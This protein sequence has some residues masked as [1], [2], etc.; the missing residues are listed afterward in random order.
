MSITVEPLIHV[1]PLW[2]RSEISQEVLLR[3]LEFRLRIGRKAELVTTDGSQ[4]LNWIVGEDD[5]RFCVNM[6]SKYSPWTVN[7]I[8]DGYITIEGG[9]RIGIAGNWVID[10]SGRRSIR[11]ITSLCIRVSKD[12]QNTSG[13]L[14]QLQGSI[15]IVGPPGSGKTTLLR[16]LIRR[17]SNCNRKAIC[18]IDERKEL[19]PMNGNQMC[20][21]VGDRTD[22]LSGCPKSK[23]IQMAIRCMGARIIAI[24]EI[25]AAED[26]AALIEA[27]WC[28]VDILATAHA[29]G[30]EDMYKRPVYKPLLE[31]KLFQGFVVMNDDK[32]WHLERI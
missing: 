20:Y 30:I 1:L 21:S 12:F 18:V 23:G 24:D 6:A 11:K 26:C 16:D 7:S 25:T 19:F 22:V 28:G 8:Y 13:D 9:H 5:L 29:S 17:I 15:L 27:G 10:D 3:L 32:S 2:L 14:Y 31:S 4:W